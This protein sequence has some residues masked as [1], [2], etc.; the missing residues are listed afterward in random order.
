[1]THARG[2][3]CGALIAVLTACTTLRTPVSLSAAAPGHTTFHGIRV[4]TA[5]RTFLLHLPPAAADRRVP[6]V[7]VFHGHKGN[8]EVARRSSRMTAVADS[9]GMAIV[10]ADGS[11]RLRGVGL[12]WNVGTC[13]GY[14]QAH[15][16]DDLAFVDS[17]RTILTRTG[18][19]DST[20]VFAAG[21][22]AGG[23]LVLRVAC[24]RAGAVR[25]VADLAGAMPNAP[26]APA[27]PVSVLLVRG[28]DDDD[29]REDHAI[30][31]SEGAPP[32]ATSLDSAAAFWS[33]ANHC[34][35]PPAPR[36]V[37]ALTRGVQTAAARGCDPRGA[38]QLVSIP[39]HPHAWPGGR[40][41][42][43]F[44]QK[45]A[46]LVNGSALVLGFFAAQLTRDDDPRR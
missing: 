16:V 1:M 27:A 25:A 46:Q 20:A 19:I 18:R 3:V 29:L 32:Y 30:H 9:L 39:D 35:A 8:A 41:T 15:N 2:A 43:W 31:R 28:D 4:A 26:C 12:S 34:S 14:A 40:S 24:E 5:T 22:S 38:V 17:L 37:R 7:L 11:G 6:L 21:F 13:C 23:M 42:W 45:P 36:D 10:F 44:G 33:R